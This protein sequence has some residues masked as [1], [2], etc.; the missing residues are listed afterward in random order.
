VLTG[1]LDRGAHAAGRR[2]PGDPEARSGARGLDEDRKLQDLDL[3]HRPVRVAQ[4]FAVGDDDIGTHAQPR[5]LEDDLHQVLV[6][7]RRG[8]SHPGADVAHVR[9]V[10]QALDRPV[11]TERPVQQG[12]DDVDLAEIAWRL[13]RLVHD[14]PALLTTGRDEHARR[15]RVDAGTMPTGQAEL[16][17][18]IGGQHP[19][20]VAGDADG[21]HVVA[22]PVQGVQDAG[23][24][25]TGDLV[26]GRAAPE[27]EGHA[28]PVRCLVRVHRR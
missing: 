2:D 1:G 18:I 11:L 16:L 24:G 14:E 22:V 23:R 3:G 9:E 28:E 19:V 21:D 12:E 20:P 15:V 13:P 4:P 25:G 6:H 27:D 7:H 26:L 5:G 10:E 17:G 8:G